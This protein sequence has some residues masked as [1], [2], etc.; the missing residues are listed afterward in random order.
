MYDASRRLV[1]SS[2]SHCFG[3]NE[4]RLA[5]MVFLFLEDDLLQTVSAS[6]IRRP[7]QINDAPLDCADT[8]IRSHSIR[9]VSY[10]VRW[11]SDEQATPR[12]A[13]LFMSMLRGHA[14]HL[15][16]VDLGITEVCHLAGPA[17]ESWD[18]GQWSLSTGT[19]HGGRRRRGRG[20]VSE[21]ILVAL[22][23]HLL[24][25]VIGHDR[26]RRVSQCKTKC[27]SEIQIMSSSRERSEVRLKLLDMEIC[28]MLAYV[29]S[30]TNCRSA[31]S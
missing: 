20:D 31:G 27:S 2:Q 15:W 26:A 6:F 10:L 4:R 19:S 7:C 8:P 11:L 5:A 23:L 9:F 29:D 1:L 21:I 14:I 24:R 25:R 17:R 18:Y 30:H 12:Q 16:D 28:S 13:Y 22:Q 3:R